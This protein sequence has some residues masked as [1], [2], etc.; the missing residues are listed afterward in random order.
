MHDSRQLQKHIHLIMSFI[1]DRSIQ[2]R[3]RCLLACR[4]IVL[5]M[6]LFLGPLDC[7]AQ[8]IIIA[9]SEHSKSTRKDPPS[10]KPARSKP[11]PLVYFDMGIIA[12]DDC[13]LTID[14]VRQKDTLRAGKTTLKKMTSG[15][16]RLSAESIATGY[17]HSQQVK[18][19]VRV[20]KP[21]ELPVKE[22]FEAHMKRVEAALSQ[23]Q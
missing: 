12:D 20:R 8:K 11:Q 23:Q 22:Q 9:G 17:V 5:G 19:D 18:V 7:D 14:G 10:P 13:I 3:S 15:T 1:C 4:C 6:F 21:F 16:H 2:G